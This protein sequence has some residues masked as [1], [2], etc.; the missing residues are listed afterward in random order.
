MGKLLGGYSLEGRSQRVDIK[1]LMSSSLSVT[2]QGS[3][4]GP[5]LFSI[6]YK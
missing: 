1:A 2:Y 5:L 3:L 4:L 6:I